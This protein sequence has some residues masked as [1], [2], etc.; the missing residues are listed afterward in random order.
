MPF[1]TS[2][3][4]PLDTVI[5]VRLTSAEKAKLKDDADLASM[6]MSGAVISAGRSLQTRM[7]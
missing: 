1:K 2:G 7:R 6:S 3:L 4:E 5:N